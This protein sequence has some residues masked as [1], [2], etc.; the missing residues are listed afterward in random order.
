MNNSITNL[1]DELEYKSQQTKISLPYNVSP[2]YNL[3]NL[4]FIIENY[5]YFILKSLYNKEVYKTSAN[6]A[7]GSFKNKESDFNSI[8]GHL[9]QNGISYRVA[10]TIDLDKKIVQVPESEQRFFKPE[11]KLLFF[12]NNFFV[13]LDSSRCSKYVDYYYN[14]VNNL[15]IDLARMVEKDDYINFGLIDG[16]KIITAKGTFD[17][18]M[19][20]I[21]EKFLKASLKGCTCF[22]RPKYYAISKNRSIFEGKSFSSAETLCKELG[23]ENSSSWICRISNKNADVYETLNNRQFLSQDLKHFKELNNYYII[24]SEDDE[25]LKEAYTHFL[26]VQKDL[27]ALD[28]IKYFEDSLTCKVSDALKLFKC[29]SK[30]ERSFYKAQLTQLKKDLGENFTINNIKEK[31]QLGDIKSFEY[32]ADKQYEYYSWVK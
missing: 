11:N 31:S 15:T 17:K 24:K 23:F 1:F 21:P 2:K 26:E 28:K 9:I 10:T 18:D 20:P 3:H 19:G 8:Y 7:I 4:N 32:K 27:D 25:F 29:K 22:A 16:S 30:E 14:D 5:C 13:I 6:Q 12:K